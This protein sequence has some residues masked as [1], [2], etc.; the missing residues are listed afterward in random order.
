[1]ATTKT[2]SIELNNQSQTIRGQI[3]LLSLVEGFFSSSV[4]FALHRLR[5]FEI[6]DKSEKTSADLAQEIGAPAE[7]LERIL[8]AAVMLKLLNCV[9]DRY[10]LSDIAQ[11]VLAP[12]AGD[13]Y[14]G[15][16]IELM[17]QF[18]H[19]YTRLDQAVIGQCPTL[20]P[21]DYLGGDQDRTRRYVYAMHNYAATR[22]KGLA[23]YLNTR[24]LRSIL[25]LGCGPG[26]FAFHL[27]TENPNLKITLAD[28]PGVL[29]VTREIH[30]KYP[31]VN[32]VEYL[33][34]DASCD[35]IPGTYDLVLASNF[36][37]CFED[38][39][40]SLLLSKIFQS[41]RPGG[42]LVVQ[43]QHLQPDRR[44]GRW[45]VFVDLNLLCTTD[46]G[47]NHTMEQTATWLSEAGFVNLE[48]NNMSV[49]GTTSFVRGYRPQ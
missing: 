42:S 45:A 29:E 18:S 8:N 19:A 41:V 38:S 22:G 27:A 20:D 21:K 3:E 15:D 6:L 2:E 23:R 39:Q 46:S 34:M 26:T 47:R 48:H 32:Q 10:Q 7:S 9:G 37:Q 33:P 49:F 13:A 14:L 28:V 31:L 4:V 44:G 24:D 17:E 36:L 5:V 25:D 16:W 1:M 11:S 43:A 12:S 40:R 30:A 35:E